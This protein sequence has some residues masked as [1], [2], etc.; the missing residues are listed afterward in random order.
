MDARDVNHCTPLHAA[1]LFDN[2]EFAKALVDQGADI[3]V[4]GD[5]DIQ[6][7]HLAAENGEKDLIEYFFRD[8]KSCGK[9]SMGSHSL[10]L[11]GI[12]WQC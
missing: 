9:R 2:V 12:R 1:C 4:S 8:R 5:F 7:I 6:P 3:A 11:C 10:T